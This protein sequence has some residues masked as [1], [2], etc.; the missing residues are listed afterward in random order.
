MSLKIMVDDE[1]ATFQLLPVLAAPEGHILLTFDDC[2]TAGDR[3]DKQ[4]FDVGFVGLRLPQLEGLA[5]ARR[6]R[7]SQLKT[8]IVLLSLVGVGFP[9][10]PRRAS[11][12]CA[13]QL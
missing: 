8:A 9:P 12:G 4:R 2:P 6:L 10:C 1:P 3:A 13:A 7:N 11:I 5:L